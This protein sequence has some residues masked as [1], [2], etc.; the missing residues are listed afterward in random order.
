MMCET[1]WYIAPWILPTVL[2]WPH[3]CNYPWAPPRTSLVKCINLHD[4]QAHLPTP[5]HPGVP[6]LWQFHPIYRWHCRCGTNDKYI[7]KY[8]N[9]GVAW[10]CT[11]HPS[12]KVLSS[13][14]PYQVPAATQNHI[15]TQISFS[16]MEQLPFATW[17]WQI[18]SKSRLMTKK[19]PILQASYINSFALTTKQQYLDPTLQL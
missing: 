3:H 17:W 8:T 18:N 12:I 11:L 10:Y 19:Y 16:H 14:H 4:L 5:L 15:T 7:Q 2:T 1:I 13:S 6:W 9:Q